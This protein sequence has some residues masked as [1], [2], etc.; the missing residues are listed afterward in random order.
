MSEKLHTRRRKGKICFTLWSMC[1]VWGSVG[2]SDA[3]SALEYRQFHNPGKTPPPPAASF[4]LRENNN[5][6]A[7]F[8][9]KSSGRTAPGLI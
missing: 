2:P 8:G 4:H 9:R 6:A 7:S 5:C 1:K 3:E